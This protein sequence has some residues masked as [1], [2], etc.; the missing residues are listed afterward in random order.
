MGSSIYATMPKKT[1]KRKETR[2]QRY[3][4]IGALGGLVGGAARAASL[5]PERRREIAQ[6][7]AKARWGTGQP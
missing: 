7:A 5:T 6:A 3:K 2:R 4:R 1:Q